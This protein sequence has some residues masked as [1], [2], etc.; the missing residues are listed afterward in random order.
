M[1][2]LENIRR[3]GRKLQWITEKKAIYNIDQCIRLFNYS[4]NGI[5]SFLYI[6]I[7]SSSHRGKCRKKW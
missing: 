1:H 6:L 5:H 4:L 7:W 2:L 3:A